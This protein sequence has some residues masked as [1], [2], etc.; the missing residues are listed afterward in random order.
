M[1]DIHLIVQPAH[2]TSHNALTV[3]VTMMTD[4]WRLFNL[5]H[6]GFEEKK[7]KLICF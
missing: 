5:S 2:L 7:K 6:N 4:L 3:T 1:Y